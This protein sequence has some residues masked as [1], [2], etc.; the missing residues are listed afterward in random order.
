MAC[1]PGIWPQATPCHL[2][3]APGV[4]PSLRLKKGHP[5]PGWGISRVS[6]FLPGLSNWAR[7]DKRLEQLSM[8]RILL[9]VPGSGGDLFVLW[10]LGGRG[11]DLAGGP[12]S[13]LS[14]VDLVGSF[15]GAGRSGGWRRGQPDAWV[16]Q[17][18]QPQ[19]PEGRS[20]IHLFGTM[21][22]LRKTWVLLHCH[23]SLSDP[24]HVT[25]F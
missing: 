17:I 16:A 9:A 4:F 14:W 6:P 13:E 12:G 3:P 8:E 19:M 25:C 24:G 7:L 18:F 22:G 23:K 21:C 10:P 11:C 5:C 1:R 20:L 2:P 15:W